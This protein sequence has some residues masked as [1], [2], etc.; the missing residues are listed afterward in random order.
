MDARE[1]GRH[2]APRDVVAWVSERRRSS[3]VVVVATEES[4]EPPDHRRM[5][6]P[7]RGPSSGDAQL[8][9]RLRPQRLS[10]AGHLEGSARAAR[11][12]HHACLC[13]AL[14]KRSTWFILGFSVAC[15]LGS[16]NPRS[17][18][19]SC[20]EG[21]VVPPRDTSVPTA[22]RLQRVQGRS[23]PSSPRFS[24]CPGISRFQRQGGDAGWLRM[25]TVFL[26]EFA[27]CFAFAWA[28]CR[29]APCMSLTSQ[30]PLFM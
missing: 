16:M 8:S 26:R 6:G 14:E 23:R 27:V 10:A 19:S 18:W 9:P 22:S 1:A 7:G 13:C 5:E 12:D 30:V 28:A 3:A 4:R 24:G 17:R 15:V 21:S 2:R 25:Y 11:R 29:F 20:A